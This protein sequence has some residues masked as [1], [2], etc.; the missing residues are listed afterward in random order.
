LQR[1]HRAAQATTPSLAS[2]SVAAWKQGAHVA[3]RLLHHL[4]AS[5]LYGWESYRWARARSGRR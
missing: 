5:V 4:K 1:P 3:R 2:R